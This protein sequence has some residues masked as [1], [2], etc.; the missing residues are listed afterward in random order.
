MNL[1]PTNCTKFPESNEVDDN[2]DFD[3]KKSPFGSFA[4]LLVRGRG[5]LA[6][7]WLRLPGRV[8]WGEFLVMK[9]NYST[10]DYLTT[11]NYQSHAEDG[12]NDE[13]NH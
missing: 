4:T 10:E 2:D 11:D 12:H 6:S 8:T 5:R 9:V 3:K 13:E 1:L 7:C